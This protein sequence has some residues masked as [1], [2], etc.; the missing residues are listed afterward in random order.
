MTQGNEMTAPDLLAELTAIGYNDVRKLPSG[1]WAGVLRQMFT[2]ALFVG[3]DEF[4]YRTRYCYATERQARVALAE[5][6]GNGQ[7]PGLW[8]KQKPQDI[9]GPGAT[10]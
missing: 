7:P 8:I 9:L 10:S 4:G 5:W 6:D 2:C 1:E 3:I